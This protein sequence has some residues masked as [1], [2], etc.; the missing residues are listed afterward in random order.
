MELNEYQKFAKDTALYP[1]RNAIDGLLYTVLGLNGE[2]GEVADK[3]KKILRDDDGVLSND[4]ADDIAKE[5]GDVLWY[6]AMVAD[7]LGFGLEYV[8]KRNIDKLQSR[9]LREVITGSGDNR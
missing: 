9:K 8:A 3:V 6:A 2:A 1:G 7:E 5:L 4:K